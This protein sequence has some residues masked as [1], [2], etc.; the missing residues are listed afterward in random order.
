M[1]FPIVPC[2]NANGKNGASVVKVPDKTGKNTSP[3]ASLAA[4]MIG[5]L[6]FAKSRCVFSMTTIASSTTMPS[7]NKKENKTIKFNENVLYP[8]KPVNKAGSTKNATHID[9]GTDKATKIAF[10]VPI[11]NNNISVT[12]IKPIMM[13][14][15][16]SCNVLF[17]CVD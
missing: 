10:V 13:V 17:V 8:N 3:A 7:A 14:L 12:K 11:K 15:I 9:K 1:N 16:K 4:F 2:Q 5:I 6:P